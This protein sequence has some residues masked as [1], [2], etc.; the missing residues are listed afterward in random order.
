MYVLNKTKALIY[1]S[2]LTFGNV[3]VVLASG[4][5]AYLKIVPVW[6]FVCT[7]GLFSVHLSR[8]LYL[9]VISMKEEEER[10]IQEEKETKRKEEYKKKEEAQANFLALFRIS[11]NNEEYVAIHSGNKKLFERNLTAIANIALETKNRTLLHFL[12][13]TYF[14][15]ST[16]LAFER[17]IPSMITRELES[18]NCYS[19]SHLE[20]WEKVINRGS[21]YK[22]LDYDYSVIPDIIINK[23]YLDELEKSIPFD[24]KIAGSHKIVLELIETRRAELV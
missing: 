12:T 6:I 9:G 8:Q 18:Y 15:Y 5:L 13:T 20:K 10:R 16:G 21:P 2:G 3:A 1:R 7:I 22:I 24:D 19:I 4:G 17:E 23:L 11:K 14:Y